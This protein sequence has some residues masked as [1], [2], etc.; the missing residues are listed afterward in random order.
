MYQAIVFLPL[1]GCI[2]AGLIALAGARQR[3][4]GRQPGANHAHH[5]DAHTAAARRTRTALTPSRMSAPR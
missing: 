5:H 4:P 1:L 2:V 3:H